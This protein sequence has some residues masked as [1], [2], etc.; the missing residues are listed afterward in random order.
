MSLLKNQSHA[1]NQ[2]PLW[3]SVQYAGN[4]GPQGPTGPQGPPGNSTGIIYYLNESDNS[5]I[6]GYKVL[7]TTPLFNPGIFVAV[8]GAGIQPIG[9]YA[10]PIGNPNVLLV[11]T[12]VW[13]FSGY[14]QTTGGTP[15]VYAEVYV[16]DAGG[17]E[18]LIAT[19]T[20]V[21][22]SSLNVQLYT[23]SCSV[24]SYGITNTDRIV[25][26]LYA[27]NLGADTLT[28][29]FEDSEVSQVTTSFSSTAP[30]VAW[31]N[32]PAQNNVDMNNQD[33]NNV[34]EVQA[35][36]LIRVG[37][38][39]LDNNGVIRIGNLPA[40]DFI[41]NLQ[42]N[43]RANGNGW[44]NNLSV[45]GP[46]AN[47]PTL[48]IN[49]AGLLVSQNQLHANAITAVGNPNNSAFEVDGNEVKIEG[50]RFRFES[51]NLVQYND[52]IVNGNFKMNA[53][54]NFPVNFPSFQCFP[55]SANF[56]NIANPVNNF[57]VA[58]LNQTLF[59]GGGAFTVN[60]GG[61]IGLT[62]GVAMN[63]IAG[64]NLN[65]NTLG[66]LNLTSAGAVNITGIG[67][68]NLAGL[69]INMF[70]G[71][72]NMGAGIINTGGGLINTGGGNIL[73]GSGMMEMGTPI[74]SGGNLMMY[75]NR[76]VMNSVGGN[77]AGIDVN[78]TG[79]IKTNTL[80]SGNLGFLNITT[81]SPGTNQVNLTGVGNISS[82]ASGMNISNVLSLAGNSTT[83][84]PLTNI[85]TING[86]PLF[87]NGSFYSTNTQSVAAANIVTLIT[88][89]TTSVSNGVSL[90]SPASQIVVSKTGLYEFNYSAQLDKSGGGTDFVDI[91]LKKNGVDVPDSA[92]QFA[93][94]G[95]QGEVVPFVNYYIQLNAGDYIEVAF[96]SPD[97]T[98]TVAYFPSQA[99]PYPRPAIPSIIANIRLIST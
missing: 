78:G 65:L 37:P 44:F 84:C 34:Q 8:N 88:Y 35:N 85:S 30:P 53:G 1:E 12:G 73:I 24:S 93:V 25:V 95:T 42:G 11:P 47:N 72:L 70:G 87:T 32:Y 59:N 22:V 69:G 61:A 58:A 62:A 90:G 36:D 94:N 55:S 86:R 15:D 13:I 74:S 10:T 48:T 68:V 31:A 98:M 4:V 83:G 89:D 54:P 6:P 56:G 75:G 29:H 57:S 26:K 79:N 66:I 23:W 16:R 27:Q 64:A 63:L 49:N 76:M 51:P 97:P 91:W 18:T 96:A 38:V 2:A 60:M 45:G 77:I 71:A 7:S 17:I 82:F 80:T 21:L 50:I 20:T 99:L 46:N 40:P 19:S 14:I 9:S 81:A 52:F 92:S 39:A 3:L 33:I 28:Y 41:A 67:S 5:D 43:V